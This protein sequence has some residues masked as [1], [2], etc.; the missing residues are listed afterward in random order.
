MGAMVASAV[1]QDAIAD[2]DGK[3][4]IVYVDKDGDLGG[5]KN[6]EYLSDLIKY[7]DTNYIEV[8]ENVYSSPMQYEF[9]NSLQ[10]E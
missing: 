1:L 8:E 7:L 10:N 5:Y 4:A 9:C 2:L 6:S 3:V